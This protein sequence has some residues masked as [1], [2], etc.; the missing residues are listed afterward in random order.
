MIPNVFR[1]RWTTWRGRERIISIHPDNVRDK[2]Q[3][4][5][6]QG[7]GCCGNAYKDF[8]CSSCNTVVGEQFLDCWQFGHVAFDFKKVELQHKDDK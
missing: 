1:I 4:K 2:E 8:H 3:L 7:W 5:F 6:E